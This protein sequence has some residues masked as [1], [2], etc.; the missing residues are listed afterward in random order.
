MKK[1]VK[2]F[3]MRT[4][5]L[6]IIWIILSADKNLSIIWG[7]IFSSLGAWLSLGLLR[8]ELEN[9]KVSFLPYFI[10]FFLYH[11]FRGGVDVAM[12]AFRKKV[13]LSPEFIN[14][15]LMSKSHLSRLIT[16]FVVSLLPGTVATS[17]EQDYLIIHVLDENKDYQQEVKLVEDKVLSLLGIEVEHG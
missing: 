17:I 1:T 8:E 6:F 5:G 4:L 2:A 7:V 12:R 3:L 16:S 10:L 9:I 15:Y 13:D 14:Y 11:S